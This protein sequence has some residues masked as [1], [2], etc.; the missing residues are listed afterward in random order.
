MTT[1]VR[2]YGLK[3]VKKSL[4]KMVEA[5]FG[6]YKIT[7]IYE[8]KDGRAEILNFSVDNTKKI[9]LILTGIKN[10]KGK[11]DKFITL[12]D[13]D[14]EKVIFT[15]QVKDVGIIGRLKSNIYNFVGGHIYFN[16]M[17]IKIRY[18]LITKSQIEPIKENQVFDHYSKVLKID[19]NETVQTGTPF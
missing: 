9:L 15:M 2:P 13:F 11:R 5:Q 8:D 17:V 12:F 19:R 1:L 10:Q 14:V 4:I 6:N 18:D 7:D 16:N 3:K